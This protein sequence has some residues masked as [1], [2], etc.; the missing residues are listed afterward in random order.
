M[1]GTPRALYLEIAARGVRLGE[2]GGLREW[3]ETAK[4]EEFRR[5]HELLEGHQKDVEA[6]LRAR[7]SELRA[8]REE[9]SA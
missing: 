9:G 1:T 8:I 2:R 3:L 6:I 5:V 7:D 4:P